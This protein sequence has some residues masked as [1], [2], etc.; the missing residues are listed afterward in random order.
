MA[1]LFPLYFQH[2]PYTALRVVLFPCLIWLLE[3]MEGYFLMILYNGKNPAWTYVGK[4]ARFNGNINLSFVFSWMAC[5]L[6]LEFLMRKIF[7]ILVE[8]IKP[9]YPILL[10]VLIGLN[11]IWYSK[12]HTGVIQFD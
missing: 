2:V 1:V 7:P 11:G 5:G 12:K 9:M 10:F 6:I 4:W 8:T 3:I